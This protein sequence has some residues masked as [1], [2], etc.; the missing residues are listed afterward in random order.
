MSYESASHVVDFRRAGARE[1]ASI[2][3]LRDRAEAANLPFDHYL[4]VASVE[5][6]KT[7]GLQIRYYP[8]L[9]FLLFSAALVVAGVAW[10]L[11]FWRPPVAMEDAR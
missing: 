11:R 10:M 6:S 5:P 7:I 2:N 3:L 4:T 8:G 9:R 1:F